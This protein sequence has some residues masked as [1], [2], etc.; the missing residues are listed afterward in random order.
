MWPL[1]VCVALGLWLLAAPRVMAYGGGIRT[2][3]E[4]FGPIAAA[5]ALIAISQATRPLRY[6]LLPIGIWLVAAPLFTPPDTSLALLNSVL[7][8]GALMA[9]PFLARPAASRFAGGWSVLLPGRRMEPE[10]QA[11]EDPQGLKR[12][13]G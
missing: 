1:V 2:Q 5:V 8:G 9:L 4:I 12:S 6:M 10:E 3:R 13:E 11:S 7:V